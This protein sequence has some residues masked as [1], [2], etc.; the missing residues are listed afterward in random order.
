VAGLAPVP[1]L[2]P[3]VWFLTSTTASSNFIS[4]AAKVVKTS[5]ASLRDGT[6]EGIGAGDVCVV[7][8]PSSRQDYMAARK[9]AADGGAVVI[10][11]A[12]AKVRR[13]RGISV[14][15]AEKKKSD[16]YL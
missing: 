6:P 5:I 8:S 12:L 9:I 7:V 3:K 10:V 13:V 11:N 16:A 1:F 4:K 15:C 14:F 2:G